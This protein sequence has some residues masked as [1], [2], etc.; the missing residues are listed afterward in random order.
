MQAFFDQ[1][2]PHQRGLS[3]RTIASYRDALRLLLE[4]I[5]SQTGAAVGGVQ[6]A[7]FTPERIQA[8]LDHLEFR[9]H[10]SVHSRNLRLAA[11]RAFLR[12]AAPADSSPQRTLER[13]LRVPMKPFRRTRPEHLSREQM[14][15][16]IAS[17]EG[18]WI[19]RRDHALLSVLYDTAATVSEVIR[20]RRL[21]LDLGTE[22]CVHLAD[23]RHARSVPLR[24][25]TVTALHQWLAL[26]PDASP[27]AVLFPNQR[28]EAMTATCIRRRLALAVARAAESDPDL[29]RRRISPRLVRHTAAM[30]LLQCGTELGVISRWLGHET[31]VTMHNHARAFLRSDERTGLPCADALPP[32]PGRARE[33]RLRSFG[34][35]A[36]ERS[37]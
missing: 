24:A 14:V 26:S 34:L 10:N 29:R 12:F 16:I 25:D 19:G 11:L 2:L 9:R 20:L 23:S 18:S 37:P 27:D 21:H 8:F 31:P 1:H 36:P 15:A 33:R 17:S 4:F 28:G 7:D 13:A 5:R 3:P 6:L 35:D 22:P 30:H 32:V